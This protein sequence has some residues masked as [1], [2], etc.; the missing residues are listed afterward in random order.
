MRKRVEWIDTAKGFCIILVVVHHVW[1]A[2][3]LYD[4]NLVLQGCFY[5]LQ[6]FR[7]PLYF[8]LSG[9]FF[10][11]YG[12]LQYLAIKKTNKILIPCV[13]F[14]VFLSVCIPFL[15]QRIGFD[16]FSVGHRSLAEMITAI[17]FKEGLYPNGP[18]W[19]L[20]CL[21]QVNILFC[22]IYSAN[23]SFTG[24]CVLSCLVGCM[25]MLMSYYGVNLYCNTDSALTAM[26]F[27]CFGYYLRHSTN[28]VS[29]EKPRLHSVMIIVLFTFLFLF[30]FARNAEFNFNKFANI[31]TV[32]P[33]GI[34]GSM[35]VLTLSKYLGRIPVIS[36]W[37]RYSLIILVTHYFMLD[38]LQFWWSGSIFGIWWLCFAMIMLS[39][40]IVIPLFIKYLPY[41][42]AQKDLL[43]YSENARV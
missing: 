18:V 38:L 31:L 8:I 9:L 37:G 34:L 27:F 11:D 16:V 17:Y 7:I 5:F 1:A 36:Y 28:F 13:F 25:G 20:I 14:Y 21:F 15:F 32:Y 10:K 33:C 3:G 41:V 40:F 29:D 35:A 39:Y 22:I 24:I 19:F 30:R 12:G 42:T 26:P 4:S 43:S 23:R 2:Y 6:S